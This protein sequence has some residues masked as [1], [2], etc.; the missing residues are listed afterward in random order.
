MGSAPPHPNISNTFPPVPPPPIVSRWSPGLIRVTGLPPNQWH[1][2]SH[3]K[4]LATK[5]LKEKVSVEVS[6]PLKVVNDIA[7][8]LVVEGAP[9]I[10]RGEKTSCKKA[11]NAVDEIPVAATEALKTVV[12][13]TITATVKVSKEETVLS[14]PVKTVEDVPVETMKHVLEVAQEKQ[15]S[16]AVSEPVKVV[17]VVQK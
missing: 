13:V 14:E 12:E 3:V 15:V 16:V 1:P 5:Q 10:A 2:F 7:T 17:E 4:H 9:E 8:E 6:K 11:L